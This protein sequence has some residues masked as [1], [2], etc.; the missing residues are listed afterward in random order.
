[1]AELNEFGPVHE[2]DE[3]SVVVNVGIIRVNGATASKSCA[4]VKLIVTRFPFP[5]LLFE[6]NNVAVGIVFI[7]FFEKMFIPYRRQNAKI[8]GGPN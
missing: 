2:Y 5:L 7:S 4:L 6:S 3:P 8:Q 1:M